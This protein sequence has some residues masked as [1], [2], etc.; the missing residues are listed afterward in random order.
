MQGAA[1]PDGVLTRFRA[2][3]LGRV[4]KEIEARPDPA[5]IDLGF[6]LLAMSEQAVTEIS[7]AVD[8]LAARTRADGNVH[9]A[10][11]AFKEGFGITF[12]CTDEPMHVAG[13][14]LESYCGLRK[15]REKSGKW[16]GLGMSSS[17]PDVRFGVSLIFPWTQDQNMDEK[18][19]GMQ[20]PIPINQALDALMRG[21]DRVKKVGRNDHCPCGSGRKYKKCCLN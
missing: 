11:F 21:R 20:P 3:T 10:T 16:F 12:H 15:Y 17:G 2:T 13:P 14:R 19:K 4:V 7:W 6:S 9:D 8:K 1:T 18:T 5:T